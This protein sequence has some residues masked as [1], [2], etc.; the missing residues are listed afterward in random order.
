[1][2]VLG[3]DRPGAEALWTFGQLVARLEALCPETIVTP[4]EWTRL[5]A[6][7]ADIEQ[8]DA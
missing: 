7:L 5:D 8:V 2:A 3:E 4:S 6:Y 1:M